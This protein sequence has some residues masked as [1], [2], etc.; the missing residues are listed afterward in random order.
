[1]LLR[2]VCV[3]FGH[4]D[5]PG[6]RKRHGFETPL[7]G[8]L[9]ISLSILALGALVLPASQFTGFA[10][11]L[12]VLL[13]LGAMDDRKHVPASFRLALQTIAV[14]VGMYFIGG[15]ALDD[16]GA[17][18]GGANVRL[19]QFSLL[20][21]VFAAVGVINAVNMIDGMDGL[22]GGFA[23]LV[24]AVLLVMAAGTSA[25]NIVLLCLTFGSV[26]GFLLFNMRTPWQRQARIFL[27]DAGSLVLGYILVWFAIQASQGS[28]SIIR[29][30]TAVWLFGLPLVDTGYLMASRMMR[31]ASP[32]AADRYHFHHLLQRSGLPPERAL[33]VWLLVAAVFMGVGILGQYA[34]VS[35]VVSCAG[36]V[37]A[38][39]LYCLTMNAFWR[40]RSGRVGRGNGSLPSQKR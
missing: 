23:A 9:A 35:D 15:V 37:I 38:F 24:V 16:L 21:T 17:I 27:G 28:T 4:V 14:A 32:L 13:V 8:G 20:F 7:S 2:P 12:L 31:G 3:Y 29:P 34:G 10:F 5:R 6:G 40:R 39:G 19:E 11:G 26:L 36:F 1:M 33:Y 30:I 25:V 18:T 22:A